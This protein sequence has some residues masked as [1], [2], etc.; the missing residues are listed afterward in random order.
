MAAPLEARQDNCPVVQQGDYVWKISNFTARKLDGKTISSLSFNI[1]A[2]NAGTLDFDCS[3]A[4]NVE[5]G[6]F[7][8]CGDNSFIYFAYQADRNGLI[9]KQD[10]SDDIQFVATT[11]LPNYCRAGGSGPDDYV[12][13]GTSPAY[14]TLVQY[15]GKLE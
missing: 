8:Q 2:T 13:Q 12:C 9:L 5:D 7:Y 11:T 6:K 14:I 3:S 4:S 15:P 10:V 1:K